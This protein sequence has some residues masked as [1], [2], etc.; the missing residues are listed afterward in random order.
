MATNRNSLA[1]PETGLLGP[2]IANA[3][4]KNSLPL[5]ADL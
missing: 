3:M 4:R 2:V 1:K 5:N